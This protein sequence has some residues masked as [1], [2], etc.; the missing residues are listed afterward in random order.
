MAITLAKITRP[1]PGKVLLRERLFSTLDQVRENAIVWINAPAG[2]GKTTLV[3]TYIEARGLKELWYQVE[4]DDADIATF[5]YYFGQAVKNTTR[6]RKKMPTLTPE[7]QLGVPE[8]SRN[9]FREVFQQGTGARFYDSDDYCSLC[10][11]LDY[12]RA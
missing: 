3:S 2:A 7:Y 4:R 6:A 10:E 11:R 8:F 1:D 9:Y 5:F 12:R